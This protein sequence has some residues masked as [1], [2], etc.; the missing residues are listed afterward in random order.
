L[1][2]INHKTL[3]IIFLVC[4]LLLIPTLSLANIQPHKL[5]FQEHLPVLEMRLHCGEYPGPLAGILGRIAL[6]RQLLED[7]ISRR[8]GQSCAGISRGGH[9]EVALKKAIN[10]N[11]DIRI[12]SASDGEGTFYMLYGPQVNIVSAM[13]VAHLFDQYVYRFLKKHKVRWEV[14]KETSKAIAIDP[15]S[16]ELNHK[17]YC[18]LKPDKI[19]ERCN[20]LYGPKAQAVMQL[21]K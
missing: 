14:A 9:N 16:F 4:I 10:G 7:G 3:S 19:V 8:P 11:K 15:D 1:V 20:M 6:S 2:T 12:S 13:T 18:T 21:I 5:Y 17:F